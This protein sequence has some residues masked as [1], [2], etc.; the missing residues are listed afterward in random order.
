MILH[1]LK[2]SDVDSLMGIF[3]DLE[4][5]RN[6]PGP[7]S[8]SEA[9]DREDLVSPGYSHAVDPSRLPRA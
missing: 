5:K 7:E 6:Y 8:R 4:A 2:M 3:S 1:P 9:E